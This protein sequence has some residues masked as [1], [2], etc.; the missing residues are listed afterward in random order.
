MTLTLRG[1]S[2]GDYAKCHVPELRKVLLK[3][4]VYSYFKI[5]TWQGTQGD[6]F[7]DLHQNR[8]LIFAHPY[9]DRLCVARTSSQSVIGCCAELVDTSPWTIMF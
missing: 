8:L 3:I 4:Y 7:H 1:G 9:K 6:L 2:H 5:S